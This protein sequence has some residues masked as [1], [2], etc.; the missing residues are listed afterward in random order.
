MFKY[1]VQVEHDPETDSYLATCRDLPLMAS[2][3]DTLD[4]ALLEAV[5]GLTAAVAIEIEQRRPVP[6]GS[7][8]EEGDHPVSVPLLVAL[9]I[10]LHNGMI[11]TG[12]RKAELARRLGQKPPQIDRLLN[13]SHSSKVETL[14]LALSLLGRR[15]EINILLITSLSP[16]PG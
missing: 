5:D 3:G 14:E 2:V 16:L 13:V 1:A 12:V 7:S 4:D 9:K 15:A 10:A 8:F 11:E 6:V